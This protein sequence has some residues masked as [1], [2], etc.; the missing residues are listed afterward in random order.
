MVVGVSEHGGVG[1]HGGWVVV[2]P[3]GAVV[4]EGVDAGVAGEGCGEDEGFGEEVE[5]RGEA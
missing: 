2:G 4:G 1:E 5:G 3:V